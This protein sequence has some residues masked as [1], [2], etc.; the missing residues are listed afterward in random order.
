MRD[1]KDYFDRWHNS[2]IIADM[3]VAEGYEYSLY[4]DYYDLDSKLVKEQ[5]EIHSARME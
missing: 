3:G 4:Q 5:I 2:A 1:A